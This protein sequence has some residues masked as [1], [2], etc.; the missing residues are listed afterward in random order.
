MYFLIHH[1]SSP[2]PQQNQA[3][4]YTLKVSNSVLTQ[5]L[6]DSI[7]VTRIELKNV[8]SSLNMCTESLL[9]MISY[10]RYS[11][12]PISFYLLCDAFSIHHSPLLSFFPPNS[13]AIKNITLVYCLIFYVLQ[14]LYPHKHCKF[15]KGRKYVL[16]L[17]HA[18]YC[19]EL[20]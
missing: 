1:N 18:T 5:Y 4:Q 10:P 16:L 8:Y 15:P 13:F 7:S 19:I 3:P 9:N 17:L 11:F 12:S 14:I 20:N 2:L 6:Y